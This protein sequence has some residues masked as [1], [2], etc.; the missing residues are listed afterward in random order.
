M[1]RRALMVGQRG[2]GSSDLSSVYSRSLSRILRG[3]PGFP[4]QN[5]LP[6]LFADQDGAWT[7]EAR[8]G[9]PGGVCAALLPRPRM[10]AP[11][12]SMDPEPLLEKSAPP[13]PHIS[14]RRQLVT[15]LVRKAL[16]RKLQP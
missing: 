11:L 6:H 5:L 9:S 13:V 8:D 2:N 14:G 16:L 3:C 15:L 4:P 7:P 12:S 1:R 10:E